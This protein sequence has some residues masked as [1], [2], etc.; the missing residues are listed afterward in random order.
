M[1]GL[2]E[3][4]SASTTRVLDPMPSVCL[5][6]SPALDES[7]SSVRGRLV[8]GGDGEPVVG[9]EAIVLHVRGR[10][11]G[12]FSRGTRVYAHAQ[13]EDRDANTKLLR[14]LS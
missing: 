9:F 4:H 7:E 5:S 11:T 1:T 13:Y 10:P 12:Y 14:W 6:F 3:P 2:N 8:S